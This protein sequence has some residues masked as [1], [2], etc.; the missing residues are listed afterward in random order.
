VLLVT[1]LVV[2]SHRLS[3]SPLKNLLL[4][5]PLIFASHRLLIISSHHRFSSSSHRRLFSGV[6][7]GLDTAQF[8]WELLGPPARI[9]SPESVAAM[10]VILR[11]FL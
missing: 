3:T 9:V 2:S 4:S 8:F 11:M 5:S 1:F 7:S 6:A 10:Q